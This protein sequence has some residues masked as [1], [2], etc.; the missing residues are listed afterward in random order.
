M[1]VARHDGIVRRIERRYRD[2]WRAAS[3]R[4]TLGF[5][6]VLLGEQAA[7]KTARW[8]SNPHAVARTRAA[9][10]TRQ[11]PCGCHGW[12]SGL[13]IRRTGFNSQA[14]HWNRDQESEVRKTSC[15]A[16]VMVTWL[17]CKQRNGVRFL[18]RA[19]PIGLLV[20]GV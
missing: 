6:G 8:G 3:S 17:S 1:K 2:Q 18:G 5:G 7:S 13:L 9:C 15:P 19:F 14:R 16:G 20:L 10:A 4:S 11:L 12:H